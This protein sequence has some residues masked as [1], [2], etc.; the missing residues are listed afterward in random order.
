M[1]F[2]FFFIAIS[3]SVINCFGQF[4]YEREYKI[5]VQDVPSQAFSLLND[6]AFDKKIKWYKEESQD[7]TTI[8]AKTRYNGFK[9]S[10]EF[11]T[12]GQILDVEK[13][14]TFDDVDTSVKSL[15]C[16]ALS[17]TFE[18]FKIRKIQQQAKSSAPALK[19]W[20]QG[21]NSAVEIRFEIVVE[22]ERNQEEDQYEVLL[23]ENGR[24]EKLAKIISRPT[25]NLEF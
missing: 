25:D 16:E 22:G 23:S 17:G 19:Q 15:I 21:E 1:K 8:E 10:I 12:S 7:G 6:I 4:K 3:F 5:K 9:Y 20:I 2:L 18:T 24:V 11:D 13:T 14:I